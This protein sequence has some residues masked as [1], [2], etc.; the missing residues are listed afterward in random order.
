MKTTVTAD[1]TTGTTA[2]KKKVAPKAVAPKAASQSS[3]TKAA[4]SILPDRNES[5]TSTKIDSPAISAE[6]IAERAYLLWEA[7]GYEHGR[8][9]EHWLNAEK[10]LKQ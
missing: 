6:Q 10:L 1:K 8:H 4:I 5:V 3:A 9:E 2:D 7:S